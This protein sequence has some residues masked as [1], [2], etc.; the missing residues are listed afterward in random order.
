MTNAPEKTEFVAVRIAVL[1]L[2]DSRSLSDDKSG[3]TLVA[4]LQAA[5][6]ILADRD[7]LPDDR[8]AIAEKLRQWSRDPS[9]DVVLSTGGTG[10]TGRDVSVEA[11]RDVY[12]KEIDAFSTRL[13]LCFHAKNWHICGSEPSN[14]RCGQWHLYV[15]IAGQSGRL[16]RCLG[17][18]TRQAIGY[19][20]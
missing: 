15:C 1:T 5:G 14:G 11:H 20:T 16:Q 2:S 8:A 6:H 4:R 13:H 17:R 19:K 10:L 18:N 3:D 7:I 9:I 12:E